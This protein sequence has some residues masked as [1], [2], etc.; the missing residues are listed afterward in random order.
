MGS[1][2]EPMALS[3]LC[4][5]GTGAAGVL[6]VCRRAALVTAGRGAGDL[7][8]ERLNRLSKVTDRVGER[9]G[10]WCWGASWDETGES[11]EAGLESGGD[12]AEAEAELSLWPRD[13]STRLEVILEYYS[14]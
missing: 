10:L 1:R 7:E 4:R 3:D 12:E 14:N 9:I 8:R 5:C 6:L 13:K 2:G 11:G